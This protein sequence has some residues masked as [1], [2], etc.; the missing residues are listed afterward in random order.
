M[1]LR[2]TRPGGKE[3]VSQG[4]WVAK[5]R[6]AKAETHRKHIVALQTL[7]A[8]ENAILP[9]DAITGLLTEF[10]ILPDK[11]V[12]EEAAV[13]TADHLA[14]HNGKAEV[15]SA[16]LA[17]QRDDPKLDWPT[18]CVLVGSEHGVRRM[19]SRACA[20]PRFQAQE[21]IGGGPP[22]THRENPP[23]HHLYPRRV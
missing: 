2:Y 6:A 3:P 23:E 19:C 15:N 13:A 10:E 17:L 5:K 20:C 18:A 12:A 1:H 8:G 4:A 14:S 9:D 21:G 16:A 11:V 7:L 22:V